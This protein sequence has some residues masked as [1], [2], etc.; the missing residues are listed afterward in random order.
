[1]TTEGESS[2]PRHS[3][4]PPGPPEAQD[5]PGTPDKVKSHTSGFKDPQEEILAQ[6][7]SPAMGETS[8]T[9]TTLNASIT[10]SIVATTLAEIRTNEIASTTLIDQVKVTRANVTSSN[11]NE[12][13]GKETT[14]EGS[15]EAVFRQR[16]DRMVRRCEELHLREVNSS[17][18]PPVLLMPWLMTHV[19]EAPGPLQVCVTRKVS[20]SISLRCLILRQHRR[21]A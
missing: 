9:K 14:R 17:A 10:P 8:V 18:T 16:H 2:R 1:M 4:R 19:E 21:V 13:K 12:A 6:A 11:R 3:E 20:I 15:L 7:I 5:Q